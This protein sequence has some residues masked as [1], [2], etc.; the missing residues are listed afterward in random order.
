M[1][2]VGGRE[3]P[4]M[5]RQQIKLEANDSHVLFGLRPILDAGSNVRN[6]PEINPDDGTLVR[7]D[8]RSGS[9]D[10][11]VDSGADLK[12]PQPG[13]STPGPR[14][15]AGLRAIPEA[16]RAQL[17][18]IAQPIVGQL[19]PEDRA[20][21][22]RALESFLRDSGE[23]RYT[24]HMERGRPEAR[25][26]RRLPRQPQG[27][28]LR[29]FRQRADAA[30]PVDR[31]PRPDGQ[32]LQGG[33]LERDRPDVLASGR[34]TRIAGSRRTSAKG[35]T[36]RRPGSPSTRPRAAE[37][38]QSV[39]RV[40]GFVANFRQ[41]TDLVRYVWVFYIVGYNAERQK[42]LLYEPI[43]QL[44]NEARKGF[45]MMGAALQEVASDLF[46]IPEDRVV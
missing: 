33:R 28:A 11:R 24:L 1:A 32:R 18:E 26:G 16:L 46:R 4:H 6:E 2:P 17:R 41:L 21:R 37:R 20:A 23:F 35:P 8:V 22:A 5:I 10:Y 7:P 19:P 42:R 45:E 34:S 25:P 9:F 29:I 12:G 15:L 30:A 40:G 13:E 27:G 39:G 38:N 14:T 31:H 44:A 43:R 36:G 3:P